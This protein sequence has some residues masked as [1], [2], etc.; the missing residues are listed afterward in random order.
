MFYDLLQASIWILRHWLFCK[1][2]LQVRDLLRERGCKP[3][4]DKPWKDGRQMGQRQS[5]S[6][7]AR[8]ANWASRHEEQQQDNAGASSGSWQAGW[9]SD[10][11]SWW[12]HSDAAA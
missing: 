7:L 6:I 5:G 12:Q 1:F 4:K 11:W 9:S 10:S 2:P 8:K 3:N